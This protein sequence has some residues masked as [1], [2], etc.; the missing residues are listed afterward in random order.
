MNY[1]RKEAPGNV[2]PGDRIYFCTHETDKYL[3][4]LVTVSRL[5]VRLGTSEEPAEQ[6]Y[7][8][9]SRYRS[10]QCRLMGWIDTVAM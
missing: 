2:L 7:S 9:V 1:L 3:L 6:P 4:Y 8:A 5:T 10:E